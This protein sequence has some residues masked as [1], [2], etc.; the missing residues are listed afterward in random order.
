[1]LDYL[2]VYEVWTTVYFDSRVYSIDPACEIA[3]NGLPG[4]LACL[5][6]PCG[7]ISLVP[8]RYFSAE[9]K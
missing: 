9:L 7:F 4:L 6:L 8:L 5:I 2:D 1:M 3:V